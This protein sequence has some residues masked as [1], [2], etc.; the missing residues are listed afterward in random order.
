MANI[1]SECHVSHQSKQSWTSQDGSVTLC[2][3]L[4]CLGY[5]WRCIHFGGVTLGVWTSLPTTHNVECRRY[6]KFFYPVVH[7]NSVL[8][9]DSISLN[10]RILLQHRQNHIRII[11]IVTVSVKHCWLCSST[12]HNSARCHLYTPAKCTQRHKTHKKVIL[13]GGGLFTAAKHSL[14][15]AQ[16]S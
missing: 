15:L 6:C 11:F 4:S 7:Q 16:E 14:G 12:N 5:D 10:V 8:H 13:L 2:V 3:L 9:V 1:W